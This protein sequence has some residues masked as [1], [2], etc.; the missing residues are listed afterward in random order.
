MSSVNTNVGALIAQKFLR[1]TAAELNMTQNRVSSGLRVAS[2]IDDASSF[3]VAAGMR[4][5]I[6]S[7]TA[8]AGALQGSGWGPRSRCPPAR[9]SRSVSRT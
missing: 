5:D 1:A 6:K 8:V 7:Y 9:R 4:A 2:A 3:A